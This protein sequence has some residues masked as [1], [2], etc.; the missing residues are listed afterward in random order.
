M[1]AGLRNWSIRDSHNVLIVLIFCLPHPNGIPLGASPTV[2]SS[3]NSHNSQSIGSNE[4]SQTR[5]RFQNVVPGATSYR[6][7]S[8]SFSRSIQ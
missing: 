7:C 2:Q 8:P 4:I 1:L 3:A 6:R 5:A